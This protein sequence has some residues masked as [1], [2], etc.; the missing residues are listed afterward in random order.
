MDARPA[1]SRADRGLEQRRTGPKTLS[2]VAKQRALGCSDRRA[3]SG[4]VAYGLVLAGTVKD[5]CQELLRT[6]PYSDIVRRQ[7]GE[8]GRQDRAACR[9]DGQASS[10]CQ[11]GDRR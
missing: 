2:L 7:P 8:I 9:D 11:R 10:G 1:R 5:T 3:P 4:E 6:K